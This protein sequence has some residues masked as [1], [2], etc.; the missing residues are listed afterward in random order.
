ATRNTISSGHGTSRVAV[1]I[2]QALCFN[3][4]PLAKPW[5]GADDEFLHAGDEDGD[6]FAGRHL[7]FGAAVDN[8]AA[9][10]LDGE[11]DDVAVVPGRTEGEGL[12]R[13]G[14]FSRNSAN[15]KSLLSHLTKCCR[16]SLSRFPQSDYSHEC[17]PFS[18]PF[19]REQLDS[20]AHCARKD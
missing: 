18:F 19:E 16:S 4:W 3:L 15:S 8:Y 10:P 5:G 17:R 20:G 12:A 6:G 1:C 11:V 9:F 7:D 14:L 2:G 13:E